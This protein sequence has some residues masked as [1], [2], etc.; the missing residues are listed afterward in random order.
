MEVVPVQ[1][2]SVSPT[3]VREVN[4]TLQGEYIPVA[5]LLFYKISWHFARR[6]QAHYHLK[7][8]HNLRLVQEILYVPNLYHQAA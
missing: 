2:E 3:A 4:Y 1:R 8:E 6:F 7:E 5:K